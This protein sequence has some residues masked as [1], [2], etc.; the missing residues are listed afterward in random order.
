VPATLLRLSS[1]YPEPAL[2]LPRLLRFGHHFLPLDD[3]SG[4]Q[5]FGEVLRTY[6][7][8][9]PSLSGSSA[10]SSAMIS[11]LSWCV[12]SARRRPQGPLSAGEPAHRG[13]V[14]PVRSPSGRRFPPAPKL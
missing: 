1:R 8:A 6:R 7:L 2:C 4:V 5:R 3:A 13:G 11:T 14:A 10:I 9:D 12:R